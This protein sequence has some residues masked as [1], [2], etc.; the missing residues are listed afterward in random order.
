MRLQCVRR[1]QASQYAAMTIGE[2]AKPC[3]NTNA[4][5]FQLSSPGLAGRPSIPETQVME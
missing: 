4:Q 3:L 1:S 5:R 2:I